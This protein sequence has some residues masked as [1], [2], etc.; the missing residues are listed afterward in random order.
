MSTLT[1]LYAL[2][3]AGEL[4]V[5]KIRD[6]SN[7]I[8]VALRDRQTLQA[9]LAKRQAELSKRQAELAK[10][11]EA[12]ANEAKT[13]PLQLRELQAVLQTRL[14]TVTGQAEATY[15]E[16]AD[17][18][19]DVV[20]RIRKQTPGAPTTAPTTDRTTAPAAAAEDTPVAEPKAA[21]ASTRTAKTTSTRKATG[22]TKA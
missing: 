12:F 4:A 18:G 10:R 15:D 21:K 14:T 11:F 7:E 13:K 2:A 16:L 17:R 20:A 19:K 22:T 9:E 5:S 6:L 3:G 1:P 8:A